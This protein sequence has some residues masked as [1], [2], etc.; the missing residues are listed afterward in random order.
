MWASFAR[1]SCTLTYA[2]DNFDKIFRS[3]ERRESGTR[4]ISLLKL[5]REA[6]RSRISLN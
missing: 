4:A 3:V 6:F 5:S 1:F 2:D